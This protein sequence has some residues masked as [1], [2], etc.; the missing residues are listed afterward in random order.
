MHPQSSTA[1]A[2]LQLRQHS[3]SL[4]S[5]FLLAMLL[6]IDFFAEE[7]SP[8]SRLAFCPEVS[9][10]CAQQATQAS[11]RCLAAAHSSCK[12]TSEIAFWY[13]SSRCCR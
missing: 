8:S 1:P 2:C 6:S 11:S 7:V 13:F 4:T 10:S 5:D 3:S 9:E 12:R